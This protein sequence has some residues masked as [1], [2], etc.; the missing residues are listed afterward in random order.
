[1]TSFVVRL[2]SMLGTFLSSACFLPLVPCVARLIFAADGAGEAGSAVSDG[3]ENKPATLQ[4]EKPCQSHSDAPS[5]RSLDAR[6]HDFS[7]PFL[8]PF[9]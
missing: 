3:L 7:H 4:S 2:E 8:Q 1:M 5:V 6:L 9:Q